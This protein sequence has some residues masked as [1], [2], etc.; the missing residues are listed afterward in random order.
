MTNLPANPKPTAYKNPDGTT[1]FSENAYWNKKAM[2]EKKDVPCMD[3]GLR[4]HPMVM[5]LDHR[6]RSS[7]YVSSSGVRMSPNKML[8]YDPIAFKDM[9]N[10][11]DAVCMNCHRIR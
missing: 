10:D 4:W 9:L 2:I 7:K 1:S 5:T 8:T 3:C 11:L 6:K